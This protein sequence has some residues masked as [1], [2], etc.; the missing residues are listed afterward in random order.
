MEQ[1]LLDYISIK[2]YNRIHKITKNISPEQIFKITQNDLQTIQQYLNKP[3]KIKYHQQIHYERINNPILS[4]RDFYENHKPNPKPLIK[5]I[6]KYQEKPAYAIGEILSNHS[7]FNSYALDNNSNN[8]SLN[9]SIRNDP[10]VHSPPEYSNFRGS[11]NYTCNSS[12]MTLHPKKS[13]GYDNPQEMY[14][15]YIDND[16]QLPEHTTLDFPRGGENTRLENK[17]SS[18][19]YRTIMQ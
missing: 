15:D 2:E 4:A 10:N 19:Y 16:M 13:Y 7:S 6:N 12:N 8:K 3:P 1:R 17:V 9:T 18:K 5:E 11:D 14:Y